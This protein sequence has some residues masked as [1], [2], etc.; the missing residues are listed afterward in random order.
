MRTFHYYFDKAR[1]AESLPSM[2][3]WKED[4]LSPRGQLKVE[5]DQHVAPMTKREIRALVAYLD[6]GIEG[7]NWRGLANCRV[8]NLTL[9]SRCLISPDK[10][11][12]FPEGW[13][14]YVVEHSVRPPAAF[15][16]DAMAWASPWRV[17]LA[18]VAIL[19]LI[20][21]LYV[22]FWLNSVIASISLI[23]VAGL[24]FRVR[25]TRPAKSSKRHPQTNQEIVLWPFVE[26]REEHL[27]VD[28]SRLHHEG[29]VG[30]KCRWRA[31]MGGSYL[32][33]DY[34]DQ[35]R[36]VSESGCY[37]PIV[38]EELLGD[39]QDWP[40][41]C[42][43]V[44]H[45]EACGCLMKWLSDENTGKRLSAVMSLAKASEYSDDSIKV[46]VEHCLVERD[47]F[48]RD[49]T[50]S[51][52]ANLKDRLT[53]VTPSL[54]GALQHQDGQVRMGALSTLLELG[55]EA[56]SEIMPV[57]IKLLEGRDSRVSGALMS[58]VREHQSS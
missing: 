13:S 10:R 26:L 47:P 30:I 34:P 25:P 32:P 20:A 44:N 5:V 3:Y 24:L 38:F 57:V 40:G 22:W 17:T 43:D 33:L 41:T 51:S 29:L 42:R 2:G 53:P 18:K 39:S 23:L 6:A 4:S 48:V 8:C 12:R 31:L 14:H 35:V 21:A 55:V 54:V 7:I 1:F 49:F 46:L 37:T 16:A 9:C 45:P 58:W 52:L 15:I 19:L 27:V 50:F 56:P 36:Y 28:L 11:W